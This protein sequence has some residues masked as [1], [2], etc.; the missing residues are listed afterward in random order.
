MN[1]VYEHEDDFDKQIARKIQG[2][3]IYLNASDL[4]TQLP[5]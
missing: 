5:Q 2:I 4:A 3:S 1:I